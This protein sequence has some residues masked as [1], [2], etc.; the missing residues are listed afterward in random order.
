MRSST[1][2]LAGDGRST[3]LEVLLDTQVGM[4]SH[5]QTLLKGELDLVRE[6]NA[7]SDKL[8]KQLES[9]SKAIST[10]VAS[11]IA[12]TR[13]LKELG[14]SMSSAELD[15]AAIDRI[16]DMPFPTRSKVINALARYHAAESQPRTKGAG[17]GAGK[18]AVSALLAASEADAPTPAF[19]EA[20]PLADS[21]GE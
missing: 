17:F 10:A 12:L 15:E 2:K 5:A 4:L 14:E 7:L 8:V 11:K 20:Y 9:A 13:R 16:K 1:E 21:T 6:G 18:S 19:D 3:S